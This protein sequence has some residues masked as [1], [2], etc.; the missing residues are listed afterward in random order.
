M[1]FGTGRWMPQQPQPI[2]FANMLQQLFA[3]NLG[4]PMAQ[5]CLTE[6]HWTMADIKKAV[7]RLKANKAADDAGLVAELLH[8]SPEVMLEAL[9]HLFR[10]VLL[11]GRV[12]ETWKQTIFNMFKYFIFG[13]KQGEQNPHLTFV[14]LLWSGCYTKHVRIWCWAEY[15]GNFRPGTTKRTAW[16]PSLLTKNRV[17][18]KTLPVDVRVWIVSLDLSKAFDKVKLE[19]LWETISKHGVSDHML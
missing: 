18:D 19:S 13:G 5:P 6:A 8:H 4:M 16:I 1:E 3:G 7:A 10:T 14:R 12:P 11:I 2:Q 15:R 17:L 9:L